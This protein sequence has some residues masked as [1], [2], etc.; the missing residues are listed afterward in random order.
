MLL[1]KTQH[2]KEGTSK[3]TAKK[4]KKTNTNYAKLINLKMMPY[5]ML[6]MCSHMRQ[7]IDGNIVVKLF[8]HLLKF[9]T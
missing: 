1:E 2:K 9:N 4:K 5:L 7:P 8:K 6:S 3:T